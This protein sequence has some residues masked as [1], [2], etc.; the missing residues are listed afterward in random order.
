MLAVNFPKKISPVH[1]SSFQEVG[2]A[3]LLASS[4]SM[5]YKMNASRDGRNSSAVLEEVAGLPPYPTH[6]NADGPAASSKLSYV[7]S[8]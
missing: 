4:T 5:L 8:L 2:S 1:V 3:I 6:S 7:N